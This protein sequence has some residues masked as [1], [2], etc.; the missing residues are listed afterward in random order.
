MNIGG[1]PSGSYRVVLIDHVATICRDNEASAD[2]FP[3]AVRATLDGDVLIATWLRARCG[4]IAFD[5]ESGQF[6]MEYLPDS[7]QL[8]GMAVYWDRTGS[9]DTASAVSTAEGPGTDVTRT[10]ASTAAATRR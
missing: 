10:S 3:G 8:F 5:F 1:R 2:L 6:A 7:D 4:D 9:P